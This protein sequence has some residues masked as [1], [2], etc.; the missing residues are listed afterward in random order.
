MQLLLIVD[1]VFE[2]ARDIYREDILDELRIVASGQNDCASMIHADTDIYSTLTFM[3]SNNPS[4][5]YGNVQDSYNQGV[6]AFQALDNQLGIV[7][8]A[9][10]IE[11]HYRCFFVTRD[12]VT[13]MLQSTQDQATK[14]LIR[15][16]LTQLQEVPLSLS[17]ACL[18]MIEE[19]WT[20]RLR[21][22]R[23]Y[24]LDTVKFYASVTYASF[25]LPNWAQVRELTV[26]AVAQD[27]FECLVTASQYS[28]RRAVSQ[29]PSARSD[30]DTEV[31]KDFITRL[32]AGNA[33]HT[34][35]A[36]VRRMCLRISGEGSRINLGPSNAISRDIVHYIYN[37]FKKGQIEPQEP[38]L[39]MSSSF[40][41]THLSSSSE[42]PF[43]F[44]D[45]N[46]SADGCVLL[47]GHGHNHDAGNQ[48]SS[49]CVFFTDGPPDVPTQNVLGTAIKNTFE[50]Y[51]VYHTSRIHRA[52]NFR[53]LG[54]DKEGKR[55][56]I[57]QGYGIYSEGFEFLDWVSSLGCPP[58]VRQGSSRNRTG[59]SL[60][61]FLRNH[62]PWREPGYI[63][64]GI[65]RR[66]FIIYKT[67]TQ[68]VRYWQSIAKER[69]D[70]GIDCC[71]ICAGEVGIG[72]PICDQCEDGLYGGA[73]EVWFRRALLGLRPIPY[74][75]INPELESNGRERFR[76]EDYDVH[77]LD[78]KFERILSFY[79]EID[80]EFEDLRQ[81]QRQTMKF[82]AI[83]Q[84]IV[85]PGLSRK[86]RRSTAT[87]SVTD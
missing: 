17:W 82:C 64:A 28:R 69:Q 12:N 76:L 37:Y 62:Y 68:E 42:E 22:P 7:R 35:L 34:L 73:D 54:K 55:W 87:P 14:I 71:A 25:L 72:N 47:H 45:L 67:V 59:A 79:E 38:F 46:V 56:N 27:A 21:I 11:N 13:T 43:H 31:I 83:Q 1:Y 77:D 16:V 39:H 3:H 85:W 32:H 29:P 60:S 10:F 19:Q 41:Q 78:A 40:D 15:Q 6:K 49:I 36:A 52:P 58:P 81:L 9:T 51:D 8:H 20:G 5:D 84:E 57:V 24:H 65:E 74:R 2:W 50:N 80:E 61:L 70:Q 66:V 23:S 63:Y 53:A 26:I 4:E 44:G 48:M 33:K 18:N 86:R 75:P 30:G